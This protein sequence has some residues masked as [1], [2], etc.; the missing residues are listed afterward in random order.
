MEIYD[1]LWRMCMFSCSW[2][3]LYVVRR[4]NIL[5]YSAGYIAGNGIPFRQYQENNPWNKKT[6]DNC[7]YISCDMICFWN[8][9]HTRIRESGLVFFAIEEM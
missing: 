1:D 8:P 2:V 7:V 6:Q 4:Y 5:P 9:T 3:V